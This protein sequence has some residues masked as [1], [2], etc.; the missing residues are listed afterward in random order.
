MS[1]CKKFTMDF[2]TK[3][4]KVNEGGVPQYYVANSHPTIIEPE[5]FDLVQYELKRR[6][7]DGRFTSCAYPFSG[8]I[9]CGECGDIY[10]SKT[11]AR[12]HRTERW[13]GNVTRS[14]GIGIAKRPI[15]PT[16]KFR[17][18]SLSLSTVFWGNEM[19][20]WRHIMRLWKR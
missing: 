11:G 13:Y 5:V 18:L 1:F 17:P 14:A 3:K 7:K 16:R 2:L 10:G 19:K 6:K 20:S 4:S 15:L 9:I 12:I 8:K